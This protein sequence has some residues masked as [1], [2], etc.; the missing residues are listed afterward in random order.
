MLTQRE[1]NRAFNA[2]GLAIKAWSS[3]LAKTVNTLNYQIDSVLYSK[4]ASDLA[5]LTGYDVADGYTK[6]LSVFLDTSG[7]FT[8][9]SSAAIANTATI[10][11]RNDIVVEPDQKTKALI[12]FIKIK[13]ASGST[14][15]GGTTALDASN[16][17]V[18]YID[19]YYPE[20]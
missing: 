1:V 12:G 15:T 9:L 16:V 17:T 14:F 13:N 5:A 8:Y 18:T 10:N 19:I 4:A 7:T 6:V 11:V 3:A 2:A 20:Y